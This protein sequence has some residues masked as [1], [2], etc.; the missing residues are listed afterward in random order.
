MAPRGHYWFGLVLT[1]MFCI[2]PSLAICSN[3]KF[4]QNLFTAMKT[5]F[6]LFFPTTPEK[7]LCIYLGYVSIFNPDNKS[8]CPHLILYP[9][10]GAEMVTWRFMNGGAISLFQMFICVECARLAHMNGAFFSWRSM[11][12][13]D[14]VRLF[15]VHRS[16]DSHISMTRWFACYI[17][18]H[19]L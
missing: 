7:T 15:H 5:C 18:I 2:S 6:V 19:G 16:T 8:R 14:W 1:N 9:E 11:G 12:M 10:Q 4:Q 17:K 3:M 13:P